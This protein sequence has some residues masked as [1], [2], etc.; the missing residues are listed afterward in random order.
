MSPDRFDHLLSLVKPLIEKKDTNFRKAISAQERLAIT[1][2]FLATGDSQQSLSFSFRVGKATVSKIVSETS[3]T[4]Y[5][6]LKGPYMSPP[7]S[8]TEWLEISKQFQEV[9]NMPHVLGCIDGKHI[10]VEC[11]KF[12]GTLYYNYKGFYSIVLMAVC[13]ANYCFTMFDLGQYGSNND[14]GI[15]ANSAMGEMFDRNLLY[16]PPDCKLNEDQEHTLPYCLLGDEIFPLK[17]WL[18]RPYPGKRASEEERIY[19]YRHSRARRCIENAF[20]VL[21]ARWR[22]FHKPIRGTV[23]NIENYTLACLALHNYLKLTDNAY[24]SPAGFIDSEDKHGNLLPGEWR[25]LNGRGG[26]GLVDV[27]PVRGSRIRKD[28]LQTRN[29]LK[30][31]LNSEEGKLPWQTDYIRRTSHYAV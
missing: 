18:M 31:F 12:S 25:L 22:I 27:S 20:G 11:P 30:D 14:S 3:K 9:W 7:E 2:R 16:A 21:S 6:V 28:A 26:N 1:L 29:R 19:N 8:E 13:D 10:R 24:Y 17:K 4:I 23:E 5:S 15:L